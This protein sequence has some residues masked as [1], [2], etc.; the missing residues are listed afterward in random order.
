MQASLRQGHSLALG[1]A[2]INRWLGKTLKARQGGPL[3][4]HVTLEGVWVS[5]EDKLAEIIIERRVMGRPFTISMYLEIEQTRGSAKLRTVIHRHGGPYLDG[6]PKP[7]RGGRFGSLV[8]PQGFLNLVIPS[9]VNLAGVYS[10]EIKLAL[11]SMSVV[12][13]EKD[14]LVLEP[15]PKDA[16]GSDPATIH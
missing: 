9:F 5:L 15:R 16:G 4:G 13:I 14:R 11:E 7:M 12:R 2:E 3:A 1:E 10:E 6:L 8:V